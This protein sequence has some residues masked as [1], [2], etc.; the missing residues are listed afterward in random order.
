LIFWN[1]S[2]GSEQALNLIPFGSAVATWNRGLSHVPFSVRHQFFRCQP[3]VFVP[4]GGSRGLAGLS[5]QQIVPDRL[6][7][8][9]RTMGD[10]A[11]IANDKTK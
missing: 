1:I 9:C 5:R 3:N 11:K 7:I 2:L 4:A 8:V 10:L 6:L